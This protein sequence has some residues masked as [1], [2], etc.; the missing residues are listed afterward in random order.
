MPEAEFLRVQKLSIECANAGA[1]TRIL[2]RV[3]ASTAIRFIA[4]DWMLQPREMHTNL[5]RP[6][7]LQLNIQQREAIERTPHAI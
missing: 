2:D 1:Q 7:R 3:I 5:V 4:D 6:T